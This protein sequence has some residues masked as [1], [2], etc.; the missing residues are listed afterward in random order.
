MPVRRVPLDEVVEAVL[1]GR[2]AQ[3]HADDRRARRR[4]GCANAV[5]PGC[6]PSTS[7]GPRA[8]GA[9][10]RRPRRQRRVSGFGSGAAASASCRAPARAAGCRRAPRSADCCGPVVAG[11]RQRRHRRGADALALHGLRARRRRPPVPHLAPAHPHRRR[12][13]RPPGAVGGAGGARRRGR[14]S[15]RRRGRRG[16]PGPLGQRRRRAGAPRRAARAQPVRATRRALGLPRGASR[17]GRHTLDAPRRDGHAGGASTGP[18]VRRDRPRRG[19]REAGQHGVRVPRRASRSLQDRFDTRRTRGTGSR[20]LLRQRRPSATR[21]P[22]RSS[23][24]TDMVLPRDSCRRAERPTCSYKG[25]RPGFV[26][27]LDPAHAWPFPATT[28]TACTSRP[29][30]CWSTRRSDAL[31][32]PGEGRPDAARGH[33]EHRPRRPAASTATRKPSSSCGS[34]ARAVYPNCPRY[35]HRYA[36]RAPV[37]V[38]APQRLPDPGAGV[39]ALGVGASTPC[40]STT[41]PASPGTARCSGAD[42]ARRPTGRGDAAAATR[43]EEGHRHDHRPAIPAADVPPGTVTGS[44]DHAVGDNG[45]YFAVSRQVPAPARRTSPRAAS[46]PTA[47]SCARGT[48]R[49]RRHHRTGG[50]GPRARSPGPGFGRRSSR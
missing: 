39:E 38:R 16:V 23:R 45:E 43:I 35:I 31:H 27:V 11:E 29:A 9:A 25:G 49:V 19:S 34:G 48:S 12:R 42:R 37:A 17:P 18:A 24:P 22:A 20:T 26:Q 32:R 50:A 10:G 4:R 36:L 1:A 14:G 40:R 7:R 46:T 13:P 6:D 15:R 30:T 5:G 47:A 44:G 2:R 8:R 28:A 33:G 21:R 3:R 41:R